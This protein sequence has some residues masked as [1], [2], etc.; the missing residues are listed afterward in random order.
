MS[1]L[2]GLDVFDNTIHK[3]NIWL[4]EIMEE[5]GTDNQRLP[6]AARDPAD[7]ARPAEHRRGHSAG[8]AVAYPGTGV[9]YQGWT[10]VGKPER[11]RRKEEFLERVSEAFGHGS[12]L[13]AE[14]AARAVFQVMARRVAEGKMA[15]TAGLSL[16]T[17]GWK[18]LKSPRNEEKPRAGSGLA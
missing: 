4:K 15:V 8:R 14:K 2:T 3:A 5:L 18:E 13:P 6:G 12:N 16:L 11:V 10:P 17:L 1:T 7:L 9:Y